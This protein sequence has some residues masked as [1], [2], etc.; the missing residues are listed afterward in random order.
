MAWRTAWRTALLAVVLATSACIAPTLPVPPPAQPEV[1]APDSVGIVTVTGPKGAV[2]AYA[3]VTVWNQT[4][5][6][7]VDCKTDTYCNPG[8]VRIANADGSF[9]V[10]LKGKSKDLLYVWQTTG[11]HQ[12]AATEV[13]VR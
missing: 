1:S 11:G 9:A 10:R 7:S 4:Y 2:A 12:S 8:V 6:E 5:A 13:H 3:E